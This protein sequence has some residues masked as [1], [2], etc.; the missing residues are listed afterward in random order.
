VGEGVGAECSTF[1]DG[2]CSVCF[3]LGGGGGSVGCYVGCLMIVMSG[4]DG[5]LTLLLL[6]A[7][8]PR[9]VSRLPLLRY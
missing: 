8:I 2:F 3:F 9:M 5:K 6:P 1:E 4:A 7:S